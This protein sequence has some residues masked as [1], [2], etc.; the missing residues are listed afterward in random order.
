MECTANISRR[1]SYYVFCGTIRS[2]SERPGRSRTEHDRMSALLFVDTKESTD[3]ARIFHK[4][5]LLEKGN[6]E[7][8][9]EFLPRPCRWGFQASPALAPAD[10]RNWL[11]FSPALTN[12]LEKAAK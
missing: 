8:V 1:G 11:C 6:L 12:I 5:L 4:P 9:V 7:A 2:K 3:A 10:R